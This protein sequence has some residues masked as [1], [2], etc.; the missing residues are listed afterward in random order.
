MNI[1]GRSAKV[2]ATLLISL[3]FTKL[4]IESFKQSIA[5]SIEIKHQLNV[6][7]AQIYNMAPVSEDIVTAV[8]RDNNA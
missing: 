8:K 1:S 5:K 6:H 3:E 7:E 4:N 2:E